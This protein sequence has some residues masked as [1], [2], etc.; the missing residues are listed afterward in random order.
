MATKRPRLSAVALAAALLFATA[1]FG[2][3]VLWDFLSRFRL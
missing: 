1:D 3:E 2:A